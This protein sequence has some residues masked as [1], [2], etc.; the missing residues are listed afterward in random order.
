V[1]AFD[2]IHFQFLSKRLA[3]LTRQILSLAYVALVISLLAG[4][5]SNT[6]VVSYDF[7]KRSGVYVLGYTTDESVRRSIEDRLVEDIRARDMIAY[8]SY[9]DLPEIPATTRRNLLDAANKRNALAVLV[10]NQVVADEQ[11]IINNPLRVTTKHPDLAAFYEYT[12][13]VERDFDPAEPVFA[14]VNAFLIE[15]DRGRL[16][17]SGTIWSFEADGEGGAISGLSNNVADELGEIRDALL[18]P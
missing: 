2:K 11:G 9:L 3:T 8:A 4:C 15:G 6:D 16:V 17:W 14:E 12:G 7:S 10:V 5:T 1:L 13:T 18:K